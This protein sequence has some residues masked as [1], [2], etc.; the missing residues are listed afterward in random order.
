MGLFGD[1]DRGAVNE[2]SDNVTALI[3]AAQKGKNALQHLLATGVDIN[4]QN[5]SGETALILSAKRGLKDTVEM[6]LNAGADADLQGSYGDTAL[7]S[8]AFSGEAEIVKML[9]DTDADVNLQGINEFTSAKDD[10]ALMDASMK[11]H[12]DIVKMLLDAGAD[13]NLQGNK[14]DTALIRAVEHGD[15]EIVKLLLDAGANTDLQNSDGYTALDFA[16]N[17]GHTEITNMLRDAS[18]EENVDDDCDADDYEDDEDTDENDDIDSME[19]ILH[20]A[21]KSKNE[22]QHL[23]DTG[24]DIDSQNND[25]VTALMVAVFSYG[26]AIVKTL[27]DAGANI[28]LQNNDG[29]T[30]L[31]AAVSDGNAD[32][33]KRVLDAGANID[34]QNDDGMTALMVAAY[35]GH[36]EIVKILIDASADIDL[37]NSDGATAVMG[38]AMNGNSDIVKMLLDAGAD[39]DLQNDDGYT[40]LMV[41]V[42][43]ENSDIVKMLLDAGADTDLQTVYGRTALMRAVI[44][45]NSDIVK[46]LLDAGADTNLQIN[47]GDNTDLQDYDG[48]TALDI[49]EK[50]GHTEI[51]NMLRDASNDEDDYEDDED[52]DENDDID[53]VKSTLAAVSEGKNSSQHLVDTYVDLS[54]N[55]VAMFIKANLPNGNYKTYFAPD[56]SD[57]IMANALTFILHVN[58]NTPIEINSSHVV[59]V[60]VADESAK[61]LNALV[62]THEALYPKFDVSYRKINYEK[63]VS[64]S[65]E[66]SDGLKIEYEDEKVIYIPENFSTDELAQFLIKLSDYKREKQD[67]LLQKI[68]N[69]GDFSLAKDI[70]SFPVDKLLSYRD[71]YGNDIL[72]LSI[73]YDIPDV[74]N[75]ILNNINTPL[76]KGD[77]NKVHKT[78]VDILTKD[79]EFTSSYDH[80]NNFDHSFLHFAAKAGKRKTIVECYYTY[81]HF[82]L[83]SYE[84]KNKIDEI[85]SRSSR[86]IKVDK[87]KSVAN[88]IGNGIFDLFLRPAFTERLESEKELDKIKDEVKLQERYSSCASQIEQQKNNFKKNFFSNYTKYNDRLNEEISKLNKQI[89]DIISDCETRITQLNKQKEK[90]RNRLGQEITKFK[91]SVIKKLNVPK[92][93]FETTAQYQ[94]RMKKL[95]EI[96]N[97]FETRFADEL[98]NIT[99]TVQ[100]EVE[101]NIRQIDDEL[102]QLKERK[103]QVE[104]NAGEYYETAHIVRSIK[105]K[106]SEMEYYSFITNAQKKSEQQTNT[107]DEK[108]ESFTTSMIKPTFHKS[109]KFSSVKLGQYNADEEFFAISI[110]GEEHILRIPISIAPDFKQSFKAKQIVSDFE[111]ENA[112]IVE[113]I[114]AIYDE[115]K[116]PID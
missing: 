7:K 92:G 52:T 69:A 5:S 114:V 101:W 111:I 99:E 60:C 84:E 62:F 90:E 57:E 8:V 32:I 46:M 74:Y 88:T 4:S 44:S 72:M 2:N 56:I 86:N 116:Y 6:L 21:I 85:I 87:A 76:E 82:S 9:L 77:Y 37:Q 41:A 35:N 16:E 31:M 98:Q 39:I 38:A 61:G 115:C 17:E 43:S 19:A 14:D 73:L 75:Y 105:E 71:K 11:G 49:A 79:N 54:N 89:K 45:E 83:L 24:V 53:D 112:H 65:L 12:K 26:N 70:T 25:G 29:M 33:V 58:G 95:E 27:L 22:L 34:L 93:E 64:I 104:T 97:S 18:N 30:A 48:C 59:A 23:L 113:R 47:A 68:I 107:V 109:K 10:T 55:S 81:N 66:G 108:K 102:K 36:T 103:L 15:K 110:D 91:N 100:Q 13:I 63:M 50:L 78:V 67:D 42:A 51:A 1:L 106:E 20:A 28:D 80:K 3:N 40:A 94:E 96:K